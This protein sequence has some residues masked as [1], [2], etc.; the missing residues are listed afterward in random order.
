MTTIVPIDSDK[1][2]EILFENA[3]EVP[4]D[5]YL[6]MMS[7]MKHYHDH[8][9]NEQQIRNYIKCLDKNIVKKFEQYIQKEPC[10]TINISCSFENKKDI[11]VIIIGI[12][13]T[14]TF[15]SGMLYFLITN[16]NKTNSPPK[17]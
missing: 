5:V 13:T 17:P 8:G 15:F 11:I 1:I 2:V 14:I 16:L 6:N 12:F 4:N 9:D 7:M 10:C 3:E